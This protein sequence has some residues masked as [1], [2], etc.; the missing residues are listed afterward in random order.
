MET[1]KSH[2]H[3]IFGFERKVGKVELRYLAA[4][5]FDEEVRR[6]F[7]DTPDTLRFFESVA[8]VP[9]AESSLHGRCWRQAVSEQEMS[10][11][12]ALNERYGRRVLAKMLA[13][14]LAA[15]WEPAPSDR[16]QSH[17]RASSRLA[18]K[19]K[20]SMNNQP[21]AFTERERTA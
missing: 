7:R 5:F 6:I 16:G 20:H 2:S 11:F 3:I 1:G 12:T 13:C 14:R 15:E 8:G 10:S 21:P 18:A 4:Q 19:P 9:Y 17:H